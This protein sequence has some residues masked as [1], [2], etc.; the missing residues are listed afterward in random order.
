M[1]SFIADKLNVKNLGEILAPTFTPE[2]EFH[3]AIEEGLDSKFLQFLEE[4]QMNPNTPNAAGNLPIHTA[5][6]FGRMSIIEALLARNI[7]VNV[8]GPRG[9]TPLHFA[10]SQGHFELVKLLVNRGANPAIRNKTGKT[11]YDIAKGDNTRQY[12]L[13][14]QFRHEDPAQAAA[15]LPPGIT[16]TVD[17]LAPKPDL[18]PPPLAPQFGGPPPP[19]APPAHHLY[20]ASTH[21]AI[22]RP[23]QSKISRE[24]RPIQADGFGSSVGNAELTAKFGNTREIKVTAPPPISPDAQ[25]NTAAISP[26]GP[27]VPPGANPFS[28]KTQLST[29]PPPSVS[30]PGSF[31]APSGAGLARGPPQFKIFNPKFVAQNTSTNQEPVAAFSSA[32][33]PPRTAPG[34]APGGFPGAPGHGGQVGFGSAPSHL[35]H[36][37]YGTPGSRFSPQAAGSFPASAAPQGSAYS[38]VSLDSNDQGEEVNFSATGSV[39]Q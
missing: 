17:P 12:L 23:G 39:V 1:F 24:S 22:P 29:S 15:Y 38:S 27:I 5:A 37:P 10:A 7:D 34:G 25:S 19:Q 30:P 32:P 18:A 13:P 2:Q 33:S 26:D 21:S 36:G 20:A 4:R 31:G 16:P 11:A 8:E 14:L 6:Y 35:P 9:N 3:A 28:A